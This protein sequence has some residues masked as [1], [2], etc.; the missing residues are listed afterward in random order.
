MLAKVFFFEHGVHVD[1][2]F[3]FSL[4]GRFPI[5]LFPFFIQRQGLIQQFNQHVIYRPVANASQLTCPAV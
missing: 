2:G 5:I 4:Y 1:V 3:H